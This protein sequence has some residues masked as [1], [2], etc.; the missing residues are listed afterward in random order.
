M[1]VSAD[2]LNELNAEQRRILDGYSESLAKYCIGAI[3][4]TLILVGFL[5]NSGHAKAL[6]THGLLLLLILVWGFFSASAIFALMCKKWN[7]YYITHFANQ[8]GLEFLLE[9]KNV[10]DNKRQEVNDRLRSYKSKENIYFWLFKNGQRAAEVCAGLG[11]LFLF[12]FVIKLL[13]TF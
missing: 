9:V 13:L 6:R 12:F 1:S 8:Q 5:V 4:G 11:L 3:S 10:D 7:G 2:K